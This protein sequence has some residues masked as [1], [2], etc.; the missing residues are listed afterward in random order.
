MFLQFIDTH[1]PSTNKLHQIFNRNTVEVRYTCTQ[2]IPQI[3]KR[4]NKKV[5]HLKRHHQLECNYRIKTECPLNGYFWKEAIMY[6]YSVNNI[7][8]QKKVSCPWKGEFKKQR[9]YS[10]T[11]SFRNENSSNSTFLSIYG[12]KIKKTDKETPTLVWK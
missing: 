5:T 4:H 10:H 1:F 9:Y 6:V 2:N 8:T 3:I 12:W 7:L 11:Q